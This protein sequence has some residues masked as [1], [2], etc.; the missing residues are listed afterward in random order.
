M[1]DVSTNK[2]DP[3]VE[4]D[5]LRAD[6]ER[7]RKE[8]H[9]REVER[10]T[11]ERD[12][13]RDR[14]AA[15]EAACGQ[16]RDAIEWAIRAG[17]ESVDRVLVLSLSPDCGKGWRLPEEFAKLEAKLHL[18]ERSEDAQPTLEDF[19]RAQEDV[20]ELGKKCD[21]LA[22]ENRSLNEEHDKEI[23][24]FQDE[25]R[26]LVIQLSGASDASIDGKGSDAGWQEF[27]LS[28]ISQGFNHITDQL[29]TLTKE[30]GQAV[31]ACDIMRWSLGMDSPWPVL[32]ILQVSCD[33]LKHLAEVHDCDHHG[34]EQ[35]QKCMTEI[36]L[37]IPRI[38]K[39]HADNPGQPMLDLL[40]EARGLL[41][42]REVTFRIPGS[43][44]WSEQRDKWNE[45]ARKVG[46][47]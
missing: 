11:K 31:A 20:V 24:A 46:V 22:K 47:E 44:P 40:H 41:N 16:M 21:A 26:N 38:E 33:W 32:E 36:S 13:L 12:Q 19:H 34:W 9:D 4:L 28:E 18:Q 42:S 25:V 35:Y 5:Q 7:L 27:T 2:Y 37:A 43:V 30:N 45:A 29:S 23:G 10:L 15:A 1:S 6:N 14:L 17:A 39:A 8:A 3:E